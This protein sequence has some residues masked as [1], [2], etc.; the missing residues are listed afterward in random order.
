MLPRILFADGGPSY[1]VRSFNP[2]VWGS[3]IY[4]WAVFRDGFDQLNSS[5][6]LFV[7][8]ETQISN[9]SDRFSYAMIVWGFGGPSSFCFNRAPD[10][11]GCDGV[12]C[13]SLPPLPPPVPP[14]PR[15]SRTEAE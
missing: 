2:F 13:L 10:R 1:L 14:A 6:G 12:T 7:F 4:L 9:A 8:N 15:S 11:P 3:S 5:I